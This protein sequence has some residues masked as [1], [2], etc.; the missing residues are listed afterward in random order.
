MRFAIA[1]YMRDL[2]DP[3]PLFAP[4]LNDAMPPFYGPAAAQPQDRGISSPHWL[5]NGEKRYDFHEDFTT[6]VRITVITVIESYIS[7]YVFY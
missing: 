3:Q 5:R 6:G 4:R 1:P 2:L 7:R